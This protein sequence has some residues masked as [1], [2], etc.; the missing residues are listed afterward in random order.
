MQNLHSVHTG[1]LL[2]I[3]RHRWRVLEVVASD[4]CQLVTVAGA[5]PA[6][7]GLARTFLLP[8]DTARPVTHDRAPRF[9]GPRR[10]RRACRALLADCTPPGA[11]RAARLARIDLLPHQLEPALA[12]VRGDGSRLLLADDVGLGKT[13]QAGLIVAELRARGLADRVLIATPAG[14]RDQWRD[15]L[16]DRFGIPST[17]ADFREIR[18]RRS[19]VAIGLNPWITVPVAI[20]S[21][22]YL[23]RPEILQPVQ[24]CRWDVVIVD[25]AHGLARESDRRAAMSTL[26]SRAA[27]VVLL[28]A[29]PHSG[30]PQAFQALCGIGGSHDPLLLFRRT[31]RDVRLGA[32]RR[33]HRLTVRTSA[34]EAR[35]HARLADF[36]RAARAEHDSPTAWLGLS[37]L[38]KRAFSSAG[39]LELTVG[40]RL[41]QL[42]PPEAEAVQL[43]LPLSDRLGEVDDADE[44]PDCLAALGLQDVRLERRL[45]GTLREAARDAA[46]RETKLSAIG[47]LLRHVREPVVV[48]T[49]FRDTLERLRAT[50]GEPVLVLH[51]G[52]ARDE[53]RAVLDA[54]NGRRCRVL[55]ATDAAGEG[56]NLHRHCRLVVNLELPWNP[57]RLE[58]RIGR[59]D[60]IGQRR[61][62]HVFHLVAG[63][64]GEQRVLERLKARIARAQADVNAANPIEDERAMARAVVG[65]DDDASRSDRR[66]EGTPPRQDPGIARPNLSDL[67]DSEVA[68]LRWVR[69]LSDEGDSLA[70][71]EAAG[72]WVI[73]A[74]RRRLRVR[75]GGQAIALLRVDYEDAGGRLVDWTLVSLS[76]ALPRSGHSGRSGRAAILQA[77]DGL[78]SAADRAAGRHRTEVEAIAHR[79]AAT[80]LARHERIARALRH[81]PVGPR[82]AGLFDRRAERAF[83]A[84]R[85]A[86]AEAAEGTARE[87]AR[88]DTLGA[89]TQRPSRLL[90][91]LV[92]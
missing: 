65:G 35:M 81:A 25:E 54:F 91:V 58:Q 4:R 24:S 51:G 2:E 20:A 78:R 36:A 21:I 26:A 31:K 61:T 7:S 69:S 38:H 19:N 18:R 47:R 75:L 79:F 43:A 64:T 30:D 70:A 28:T 37:V 59:V 55:L 56:L 15:E 17:I 60:R 84:D 6:N 72:P 57:M 10:W 86:N 16:L 33:V 32:G 87:I 89:I 66:A 40:R 53:R 77:V 42:G 73:R 63:D 92:P 12:V 76:L 48:F 27:Y 50:L 88:A 23:K 39:S 90:L 83:H 44:P 62:V 74:R 71:L 34:A 85:G 45:L 80:L 14:L 8:F 29:T 3:R 52:M 1:D 9:V 11:L 68:R 67:A 22:D 49:E 46:A 41:A 13:I 82:Q 5:G